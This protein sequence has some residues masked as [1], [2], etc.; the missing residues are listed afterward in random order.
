ML[1]E[2]LA[3]DHPQRIIY[4]EDLD[5]NSADGSAAGK[6]RANPTE[7]LSPFVAPWIKEAILPRAR[8]L[9]IYSREIGPL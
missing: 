6:K 8:A 9:A 5:R 7:V 3:K 4:R 1:N 2:F